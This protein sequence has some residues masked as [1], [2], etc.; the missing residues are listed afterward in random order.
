MGARCR[1]D[2][3]MAWIGGLRIASLALLIMSLSAHALDLQG[4]RGAR[5]LLPEN[6]LPAFTR[7][8]DLGMTTLELDCGVTRDGVVVV[9]HD[10]TLS[11]EFTRDANGAWLAG[12]PPAI[13]SFTYDALRRYDVGRLKPGTEYAKRFPKQQP[14]DGARIPA[15]ADV[16][17]LVRSRG[18]S[19]VRFNIET[20][21]SPLA[22]AETAAP[23]AFV[24][25]LLGA[26]RK[27][28]M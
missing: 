9:A 1:M 8:L 26:I 27:A 15:L 5:G 7:A 11:P 25:A 17:E 16:F 3:V 12:A 23:E 20:K 6:T 18:D 21:L 2:Q 10:R 13:G 4:H 22:S 14:V 28:G 19:S 24:A